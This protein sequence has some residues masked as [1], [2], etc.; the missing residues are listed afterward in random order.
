MK[1]NAVQ[2]GI[3]SQLYYERDKIQFH[4]QLYMRIYFVFKNFFRFVDIIRS[5]AK[6]VLAKILS[7]F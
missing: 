1:K 6:I 2:I 4:V 3:S 5:R 7:L